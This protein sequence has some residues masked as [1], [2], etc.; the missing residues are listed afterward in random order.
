MQKQLYG[1]NF[2]WFCNLE[3]SNKNCCFVTFLLKINIINELS[4]S[5]SEDV[6]SACWAPLQHSPQC[7]LVWRAGAEARIMP[8]T[9]QTFCAATT[10]YSWQ[11]ASC[12]AHITLPFIIWQQLKCFSFSFSNTLKSIKQMKI[13]FNLKKNSVLNNNTL[14]KILCP[15]NWTISYH[16]KSFSSYTSPFKP[17]LNGIPPPLVAT[18]EKVRPCWCSFV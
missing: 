12:L 5:V 1:F 6:G 3:I 18:F 2:L 15:L 11:K 9:Y 8:E 17:T 7:M 4:L 10:S 14:L 16:Q 13:T